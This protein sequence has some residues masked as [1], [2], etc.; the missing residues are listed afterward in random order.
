[1]K[2]LLIPLL[3]VTTN[4]FAQEAHP[5]CLGIERW[6]TSMA[7]A[8]LKND[9]AVSPETVDFSKTVTKRIASEKIGDDLY[10]QVHHIT[11]TLKSGSTIQVITVNNASSEECSMSDVDVYIISKQL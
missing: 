7:Y 11:F 8:T 10:K 5:N 4:L 3:L 6:A 9:G 1:M 2:Y